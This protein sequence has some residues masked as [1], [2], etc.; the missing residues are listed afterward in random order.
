MSDNRGMSNGQLGRRPRRQA[1]RRV[2]DQAGAG[3]ERGR[4]RSS[5]L[6]RP[7][8]LADWRVRS[9]L[10][11]VLVIPLAAFVVLAGVNVT[12]S[13]RRAEAFGDGGRIAELARQVSGVT[14]ELQRERDLTA[15]WLVSNSKSDAD[16][17]IK[18]RRTVDGA[19]TAYR[20]A[21]A[22]LY[23]GSEQSLRAAFDAVRAGFGSLGGLR[24]AT[25]A[26]A[27]AE[28]AVFDE[29][30]GIIAGL[31]AVTVEVDQPGEDDIYTQRARAFANLAQ[32]K[33]L[34]AQIRGTM[35]AVSYQGGFSF[36]QFQEF[37]ELLARQRAG[38]DRF[39]LE[40]IDQQRGLYAGTVKGQAVLAVARIRQAAVNR[41]ASATLDIDPQQWFAASSTELELLR[42]VERRLLSDAI[43]QGRALTNQA[44]RNAGTTALM[45]A[46]TLVIA[47]LAS[48]GVAESMARPLRGLQT[49]AQDIA[50][51][52]LP[53]AVARLRTTTTGELDTRVEPVG[54]DTKDEI[55]EVAQAFDAVHHQAVRLAA[56]QAALRS[57]VSDMFL[58][59]A[60]RNQALI[61]RLLGRISEL[62]QEETD[63]VELEN[64]YVL[65]HLAT[66]MRRNAENL[67]VLSGAEP[68][69][70]R[71]GAPVPLGDVVEAAVAEIED[72]TRVELG[73]ID[74][75]SIHGRAASDIAHLLAELVEN[76]TMFSPPGAPVVITGAAVGSGFV[77]EIEDRGLGMS[78]QDLLEA[79]RRLTDPP[80]L[81]FSVRQRLG[82]FVVARLARRYGIKVQLRHSAYGG[83]AALVG[84][85]MSL[86]AD[87]AAHDPAAIQSADALGM[88]VAVGS[89][90]GSTRTRIQTL[91]TDWFSTDVHSVYLPL[92]PHGIQREPRLPGGRSYDRL[93]DRTEALTPRNSAAPPERSDG[94]PPRPPV[95]PDG[96]QRMGSGGRT[97]PGGL[98]RRVPKERLAAG[99]ATPPPAPPPGRGALGNRRPRSAEARRSALANFQAGLTRGRV[100]TGK[101][102]TGEIPSPPPPAGDQQ[103]PPGSPDDRES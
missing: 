16:E 27:L 8:W 70:R 25:D 9:K 40:A 3:P 4:R 93:L 101:D 100:A 51:R 2:P 11:A 59:L 19:V 21:E 88:S 61:D 32:L 97:A 12:A 33:E 71:W 89:L 86:L 37:A 96:D 30:T 62:E 15:G 95:P 79:N 65:D 56:E 1:R 38:L 26:R 18:Q 28:Q 54:I 78:D 45:I 87:P 76:A 42:T 24:R 44:R 83:I 98:P 49:A 63:P 77:L 69:L 13:V 50:D 7:R 82:L 81:D 84:L 5:R 67:V 75:A 22:S 31:L 41:Q 53:E 68:S 47:L 57:N 20:E 85:P 52:R 80:V 72:Y 35:Y 74:E 36:G 39:L 46:I 99:L 17:K 94:S 23:G 92:R 103:P 102:S 60:R 66:R 10:A 58:N 90:S 29:Y 64:L 43:A 91:R 14:H 48:L 55:G 34:T 6:L 73:V